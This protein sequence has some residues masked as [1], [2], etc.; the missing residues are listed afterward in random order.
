MLLALHKIHNQEGKVVEDV[1]SGA[2]LQ[3]GTLRG[4]A[5]DG[6]LL[7]QREAASSSATAVVSLDWLRELRTLL[8]PPATSL[9]R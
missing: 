3:S 7:L 4:I 5:Q 6:R 2:P 9:P 8:G 1:T